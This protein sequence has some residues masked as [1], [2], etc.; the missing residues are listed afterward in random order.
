M[1]C[2]GVHVYLRVCVCVCVCVCV[3]VCVCLSLEARGQL[4]EQ[5]LFFHRGSSRDKPH[6][7]SRGSKCLYQLSLP[8]FH[9][10]III[11]IIIIKH[12]LQSHDEV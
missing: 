6:L 2:A 11:I 7:L 12:T 5:I 9:Q 8:S 10:I 3:Y 4:Q 1:Y